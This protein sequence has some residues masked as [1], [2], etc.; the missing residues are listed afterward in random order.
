MSA[1]PLPGLLAHLAPL[2]DHYGYVAIGSFVMLEDF[3][4]PVPGETILIAAAV[5]AGAGRLNVF[6]VGLIAVAAAVVG[7]NIGYA[8]GRFGGRALV[9]RFGKY[10][11]L[12]SERL[13]KAESFFSRYGGIVV[14]VARFIEGLRQANGIVAGIS[15]MPWPRFL[16]FNALGAAL[17]VA[18]WTSIGYLAGNH[19]TTIYDAITR[20]SLYVLIALAAAVIALIIRTV[21]RRRSAEAGRALPDAGNEPSVAAG[22]IG[23]AAPQPGAQRGLLHPDSHDL[24]DSPPD[25]HHHGASEIV[26]RETQAEEQDQQPEVGGVA[27][28][29][30]RPAGDQRLPRPDRGERQAGG[31]EGNRGNRGNRR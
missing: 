2:L 8:I 28:Q 10:V 18:V 12:T 14:T 11:F 17:W 20:Y 1:Q 7:D 27:S 5:Y 23:V 3:G 24:S 21:V 30:L 26:Q 16:A 13:D 4:V 19:I 15:E 6:A 31:V 29:P 9:L 25:N 22:V